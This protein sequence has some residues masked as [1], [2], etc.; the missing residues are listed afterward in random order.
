[1]IW[2]IDP[3]LITL[4]GFELRYYSLCFLLSGAL[5][6][7]LF[8]RFM[9]NFG[10]KTDSMDDI[11]IAGVFG[12][13]IGARL[14]HCFFYE[15]EYFFE[16]PGEI[17]SFWNGGL[18]SHGA[19]IGI[20]FTVLACAKIKKIP[21]MLLADGAAFVM[22]SGAFFV[23]IGNFFNSEIAGKATTLP[24]GVRFMQLD[25][26]AILRHPTQLYEAAGGLLLIIV[27][28]IIDKKIKNRMN[29]ALF[30]FFITTYNI[31]RF[32][33]EFLKDYDS[34][35]MTKGQSLLTMGQWLSLTFALSGIILYM[36]IRKLEKAREIVIQ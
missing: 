22:A 9:K 21:V 29:G 34:D 5:G 14:V 24:W 25:E 26:G 16:H 35:L 15:P 18:A 1:M 19:A 17:I 13:F 12:M 27:I 7:F 33:V 32:F 23:R 31:L 2:N 36:I 6:Y 11:F 10:Y 30:C 3:V 4:G 28:L 8:I 20:F